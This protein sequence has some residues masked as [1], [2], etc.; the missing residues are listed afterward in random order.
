MMSSPSSMYRLKCCKDRPIPNIFCSSVNQQ[1]THCAQT[2]RNFNCSCMMM[3]AV[4][5]EQPTVCA[6]PSMDACWSLR[7]ICFTRFTVASVDTSAGRPGCSRSLMCCLPLLN[8][9]IQLNTVF[10]EKQLSPYMDSFRDALL[11]WTVLWPTKNAQPHA[12]PLVY[13]HATHPPSCSGCH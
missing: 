6:M 2:L 3:Y 9:W 4:P 13:T 10:H 5:C 7:M 12:V 11:L 8:S 1:S